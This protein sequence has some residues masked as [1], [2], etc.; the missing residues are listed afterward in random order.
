ME[1]IVPVE[2]GGHVNKQISA[3]KLSL[4]KKYV[5]GMVDART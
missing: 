4:T 2:W 5:L 1:L 3:A